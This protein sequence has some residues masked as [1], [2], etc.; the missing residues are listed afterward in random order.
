MRRK[1]RGRGSWRK[2]SRCLP[3]VFV[4]LRAQRLSGVLP[5][6][7]KGSGGRRIGKTKACRL[8]YS[9]CVL[10]GY[11]R[12]LCQPPFRCLL[13]FRQLAQKLDLGCVAGQFVGGFQDEGQ[14]A[15]RG[16]RDDALERVDADEAL[17]DA[18]VAVLV[19]PAGFF[20]SL[21]CTARRR[22]RPI[23]WSNSSSTPSRSFTMS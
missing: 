19:R 10:S 22:S 12:A 15:K 17:A 20:E 4:G 1:G 16:V 7:K 5:H 21:M 8:P 6:G 23:T 2:E 18:L 9:P 3:R 11:Q 13:P 14:V